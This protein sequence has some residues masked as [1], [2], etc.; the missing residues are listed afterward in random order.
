MVHL[1]PLIGEITR[2]AK[3]DGMTVI[4][5]TAPMLAANDASDLLELVDHV[6]VVAMPGRT[7]ARALR[8]SVEILRRND[9]P[10]AGA[11]L[12][13]VS[14][15]TFSRLVYYAEYDID[16]TEAPDPPT[17]GGDR[18]DERSEPAARTSTSNGSAVTGSVASSESRVSA[19]F[20]RLSGPGG[21]VPG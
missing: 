7:N 8:T 6:I 21:A 19:L 5:D 15:K 9:A 2:Q 17:F 4:I 1:I 20:R 14:D 3:A 12:V 11:V 16:T 18:S 10:I 13:G